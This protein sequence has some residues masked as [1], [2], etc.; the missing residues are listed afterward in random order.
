MNSTINFG[1]L[2]YNGGSANVPFTAAEFNRICASYNFNSLEANLV[3]NCGCGPFG[4]GMCGCCCGGCGRRFG[5]GY[6][7]GFRYINFSDYFLYST[8]LNGF[9]MTGTDPNE[10]NYAVATTNNL[11]GFQVGGGLSYCVCNRLTAFVIGKAGIYDNSVTALQKVYG[12][13]GTAVIAN[14]P[15]AGENFDVRSTGLN[16]FAMSGQID[17]GGRWMITNCLTLNFGYRVLGLSG[18]ATTSTNIVQNNF[19]DV[20]GIASVNRC[21]S[22]LLHGAFG[23]LVYCF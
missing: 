3:G 9:S 15:H 14:G 18:V 19:H 17:F 21:G 1:D 2:T 11:F 13:A 16:N 4:C 22:F 5:F 20:D 6:T 7:A 10:L 12:P 8:S 23:G